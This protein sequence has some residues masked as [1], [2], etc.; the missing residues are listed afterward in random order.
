M[1]MDYLSSI[2]YSL[3]A[4]IGSIFIAK[5][6]LTKDFEC[7]IK[8]FIIVIILYAIAISLSF[9]TEY[10][11]LQTIIKCL[12]LGIVLIKLF[13]IKISTAL[14]ASI[15]IIIGL[16]LIEMIILLNPMILENS[17]L[18]RT[19][20]LYFT[21]NHIL[22][23]IIGYL[24]TKT[25]FINIRLIKFLLKVDK[26]YKR[27]E[28]LF[29]LFLIL[30]AV[31]LCYL[32]FAN[33]YISVHI[34]VLIMFLIILTVS[35][36]IFIY[37]KK[38]Y[39]SLRDK[40]NNL[41]EYAY[42]YEEKFENDKLL[43]HEHQNQLAV[44][45]GMAKNKKVIQYIDELLENYKNDFINVKGINNI[46]KGGLRGL[47]YYKICLINKKKINY[48]IDISGNVKRQFNKLSDKMRKDLSY[49]IGVYLDNAIEECEKDKK[50]NLMIE[51]YSIDNNISI[52]IS[53][54]I[55]DSIELNKIGAKGYTTKGLN[56]G[57]GL[58]LVNKIINSS[59]NIEVKTRIINIVF[60]QEIKI[61]TKKDVE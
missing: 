23:I 24:L 4:A 31:L 22:T 2:P 44:I 36:Y 41:L 18:V 38:K 39:A 56:H 9:N 7:N 27:S 20:A 5:N 55:S 6:I 59:N 45:K 32:V 28:I 3:I 46:P 25:K 57:N 13:D 35:L 17:R 33:R 19:N 53:N 37:E 60:V 50:S 52:I 42:T 29:I 47:I 54:T 15:L 1:L 26:D 61:D 49:I 8:E 12:S 40:Y 43:R 51:I 34:S 11:P 48:N 16:I 21:V 30:S 58:Y 10:A 14:I